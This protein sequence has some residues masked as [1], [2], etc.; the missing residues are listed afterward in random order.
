[1]SKKSM[2]EAFGNTLVELG[3]EDQDIVVV[4][5]DLSTSTKTDI[6]KKVFSERFVDVGIAEQNLIG[7]SSGIAS[8]GKKVFAS[9]FAV[10]ETGRAYEVIRNMTCME[11]LCDS[12]WVDD[13]TRWCN[14]SIY[15]GLGYNESAT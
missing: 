7:V 2:R 4:D 1:M 13:R 5:A 6:F 3:E 10:F 12:C 8:T 14:S 11:A 9:S 15:R